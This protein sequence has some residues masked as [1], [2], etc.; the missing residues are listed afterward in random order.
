[1]A[2]A[3]NSLPSLRGGT[4]AGQTREQSAA[5]AA[6]RGKR[7]ERGRL[8]LLLSIP[9]HPHPPPPRT[10]L[11]PFRC[12]F[13]RAQWKHPGAI[14]THGHLLHFN[15]GF[16]SLSLS[17]SLSFSFYPPAPLTASPRILPL[18]PSPSA[19]RP[20]RP[21][22]AYVQHERTRALHSRFTTSFMVHTVYESTQKY[23]TANYPAS[24]TG[25]KQLY[26]SL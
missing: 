19:S 11:L 13:R 8:C 5:A 22:S 6:A 2:Y 24:T 15:N 4:D 20:F 21:L 18:F 16:P 3:R 25:G 9:P 26:Y 17:L 1:M 7:V 12:L 10:L 23:P 14:E